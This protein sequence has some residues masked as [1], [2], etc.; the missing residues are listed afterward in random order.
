MQPQP[1]PIPPLGRLRIHALP[2]ADD[3]DCE[4]R[5]MDEVARSGHCTGHVWS[6]LPALVAPRSYLR[7]PRW[8]QACQARLACG[9]RVRLRASGGGLVPQGPGLLNLS[10]VWRLP[11]A[12]RPDPGAI[13]AAFAGA[14]TRGLAGLGIELATREVQGSFCDGRFN[15]AADGRKCIGTAQAWKRIDGHLVVL[16]HAV[17]VVN[18]QVDALC[19]VLNDFERDAGGTRRYRPE[20][21][22]SLAQAWCAAHAAPAAPGDFERR[23]VGGMLQGFETAGPAPR[24]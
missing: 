7:L 13:Y 4:P 2:L 21:V 14:L 6:A 20:A 5:W 16:A 17:L 3:A 10:L 1:V 18:A 12:L 15:L 9:P 22:I 11:A 19:Q 23:V 8:P 24:H